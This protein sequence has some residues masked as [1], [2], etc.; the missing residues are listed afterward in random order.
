MVGQALTSLSG[1]LFISTLSGRVAEQL[2]HGDGRIETSPQLWRSPILQHQRD[3]HLPVSDKPGTEPG[4]PLLL[5]SVVCE[6]KAHMCG[7]IYL[8]I[9]AFT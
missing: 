8:F 1:Q 5:P 3:L 6:S 9:C 4:S 7:S 2:G